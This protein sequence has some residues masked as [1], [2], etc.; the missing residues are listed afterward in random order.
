[1]AELTARGGELVV[2]IEPREKQFFTA[3]GLRKSRSNLLTSIHRLSRGAFGFI[4]VK[5][6]L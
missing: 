1:M 4:N 3:F 2:T 5:G 6:A